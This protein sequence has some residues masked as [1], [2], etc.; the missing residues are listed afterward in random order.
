MTKKVHKL[1]LLFLAA[2]LLGAA[3]AREA[4]AQQPAGA[5]PVSSD[6][7][8]QY[9]TIDGAVTNPGRFELR[10]GMRLNDLIVLAGD[11]TTQAEGTIRITHAAPR[12]NSAPPAAGLTAG[13]SEDY[14]V[15][16]LLQRG[17]SPYLQPGDVVTIVIAQPVYVVGNV[18]TPQAMAFRSGTSLLDAI[19]RAGGWLKNS[20]TDNVR[21]YRRTPDG[22][23]LEIIA[24]NIKAIRERR[25]EDVRLQPHDIIEV[26]RKGAP[27]VTPGLKKIYPDYAGGRRVIY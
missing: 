27:P 13:R 21:I 6:A 1:F 23:S 12:D 20:K 5:A 19:L 16:D 14:S 18:A 24:A 22:L 17:I 9:V 2:G 25:A 11:L 4:L 26:P 10:P 7:K 8:P 3:T 15:V